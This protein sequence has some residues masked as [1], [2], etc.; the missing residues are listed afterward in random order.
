ML[1][2][3]PNCKQ[4]VDSE[5]TTCQ[6]CGKPILLSDEQLTSQEDNQNSYDIENTSNASPQLLQDTPQDTTE[7]ETD[8]IPLDL[9]DNSPI[10]L[11]P[12][13]HNGNDKYAEKIIKCQPDR[14]IYMMGKLTTGRAI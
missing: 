2:Q 13:Y 10:D 14:P 5:Y 8:G 4:W 1:I 6:R 7:K 9:S 11:M 3:C 12:Y